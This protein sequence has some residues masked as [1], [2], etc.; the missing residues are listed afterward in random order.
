MNKPLVLWIS[1]E[2]KQS[3]RMISLPTSYEE[4]A[5]TL[6]LNGITVENC[7]IDSCEFESKRLCLTDIPLENSNIYEVNHLATLLCDMDLHERN[8]FIGGFKISDQQLTTAHLINIAMN[9]KTLENIECYPAANDRE[10]GEFHLDCESLPQL[11]DI[12]NL[13]ILIPIRKHHKTDI[14]VI[15]QH[16]Y[17]WRMACFQLELV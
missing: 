4:I 2:K 8:R 5:D 11:D 6:D 1:H 12:Q 9:V 14:K 10:L 7:Y 17:V 16:F 3:A 13:C 15:N